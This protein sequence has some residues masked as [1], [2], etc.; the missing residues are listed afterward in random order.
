M[1]TQPINPSQT[2]GL[3]SAFVHVRERCGSVRLPKAPGLKFEHSAYANV[4]NT[5]QVE[6]L[7]GHSL[8]DDQFDRQYSLGRDSQT[9]VGSY[10]LGMRNFVNPAEISAGGDQR[11]AAADDSHSPKAILI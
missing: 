6:K 3:P 4:M 8:D 2:N 7:L 9:E 11:P 1:D 5:Q 10:F